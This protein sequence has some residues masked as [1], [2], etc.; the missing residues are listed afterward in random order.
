LPQA[1]AREWGRLIPG[2]KVEIIAACGHMPPIE[3]T[4]EFVNLVSAFAAERA[5]A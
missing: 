5:V 2:S 4:T 1:Y 3:K